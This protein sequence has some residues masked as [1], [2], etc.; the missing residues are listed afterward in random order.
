MVLKLYVMEREGKRFIYL[1]NDD[2]FFGKFMVGFLSRDFKDFVF[3]ELRDEFD[4][5]LYL[6]FSKKNLFKNIQFLLTRSIFSV[7][8]NILT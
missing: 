1:I 6:D 5:R 8:R 2:L 7:L 3:L 4:E